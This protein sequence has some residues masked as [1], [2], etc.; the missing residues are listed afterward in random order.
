MKLQVPLA[1]ARAGGRGIKASYELVTVAE[2]NSAARKLD[3]AFNHA[4]LLREVHPLALRVGG[5][6]RFDV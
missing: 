1:T 6:E 4:S 3:F 5:K 2:I